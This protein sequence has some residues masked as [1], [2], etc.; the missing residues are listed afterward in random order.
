MVSRGKTGIRLFKSPG[1]SLS[2]APRVTAAGVVRA[3]MAALCLVGSV[4]ATAADVRAADPT[5][6]ATAPSENAPPDPS[7]GP[8]LLPPEAMDAPL[9]PAAPSVPSGPAPAPAAAPAATP[10]PLSSGAMR[11][12]TPSAPT[13][14][15]TGPPPVAGVVP[16][17]GRYWIASSWR[18][19]QMAPHGCA[20]GDLDFYHVGGGSGTQLLNRA[21]FAA[22]LTPG[23]PVCIV[24]HGSF[25]NWKSLCDDCTPVLRWI[26]SGAPQRPLH[27]LFYTWPSQ[28]ASP[29]SRTPTSPSWE[30]A[31]SFN[32][33]YLAE[34][35]ARIP[36]GHP[37]C[38]MGHSHGARM[39]AAALH[40]L[41]GGE[42]DNVRLTWPA[43]PDLRVRGVLVAEVLDASLARPGTE[44]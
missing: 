17:R 14:D 36:P 16:C 38:L 39:V 1:R 32:S 11:L 25:T 34:L 24:V 41:G 19:R 43:P 15:F 33:I 23:V 6:A 29:T 13:P 9:S 28:G 21:A 30:H 2:A 42:V 7:G 12:Q 22:S 40:V 10:A 35:V 4:A 8:Q 44:V 37:V 26:R 18:C 5:V 20:C 31:A 27:V 3:V